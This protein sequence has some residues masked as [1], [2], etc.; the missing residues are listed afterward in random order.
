MPG[1]RFITPELF[2]FLRA[3]KR[4]NDREWFNANKQRYIDVVRDPLCAFVEAVGPGLRAISPSVVADSRPNGGSLF[5]IYRDTRFSKDKS[6]YKT[7]QGLHFRT[8]PKNASAPS[9]YLHLAPG[10]VFVGAGLW[11]PDNDALRRIRDAID[12][13]PDR[14]ESASRIG[15]DDMDDALKRPP[16]GYDPDHP[17]IEDLKRKSFCASA[18]FTEK[19][20]CAADFTTRF[21]RACRRTQ[22]LMDF[23]GDAVGA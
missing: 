14:W 22:P 3:L 15:L 23:L 6:P 10:E 5:R 13:H 21:I 11:H 8:G 9:Y 20:A 18:D 7:A 17:N 12:E 1:A 19:Q 16:R 4:N 2:K